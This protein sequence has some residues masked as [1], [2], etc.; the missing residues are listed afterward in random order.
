M[1]DF[2]LDKHVERSDDNFYK[3][4]KKELTEDEIKIKDEYNLTPMEYEIANFFVYK[5]ISKKLKHVADLFSINRSKLLR[6]LN[7]E[8]V[9]KYIDFLKNERREDFL[10]YNLK[11]TTDILNEIKKVIT[12][13]VNNFKSTEDMALMLDKKLAFVQEYFKIVKGDDKTI[14]ENTN[15][16]GSNIININNNNTD[17]EGFTKNERN[18][19]ESLL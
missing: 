5:S 8:N 10:K 6:I 13:N 15:P 2:S 3:T 9:K 14:P 4:F 11:N 17:K 1:E 18:T 19:L 12:L 7:K 16:S